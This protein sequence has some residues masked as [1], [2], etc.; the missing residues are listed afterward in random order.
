MIRE[1]RPRAT[2][3]SL[4]PLWALVCLGAAASLLAPP[5]TSSDPDSLASFDAERAYLTGVYVLNHERRAVESLPYFRLAVA[6]R[7]D[8][9]QVHCDYAAALMDAVGEARPG[10]GATRSATRS[11]WERA[12]MIHEALAELDRGE[13]LASAPAD[14]A[15]LVAIRAQTLAIWGLSWNALAEYERALQID[16]SSVALRQRHTLLWH[17]VRD[18]QWTT[19]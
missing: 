8:L 6:L 15:H 7:P 1:S 4:A 18:P 13:P 16:S 2:K 12:A 11:S 19:P 17:H 14:R 3:R 9:W 5:R 10:P